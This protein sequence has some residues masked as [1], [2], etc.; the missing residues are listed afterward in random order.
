MFRHGWKAMVAS[1]WQCSWEDLEVIKGES[2]A[3]IYGM[4]P[5]YFLSAQVLGVRRDTP[6]SNR[7]LVIEPHLGDLL[8]ADGV[9]VTE[10]GP[11]P[12]SWKKTDGAL[13]FK[14]TIPAN[15]EARLALPAKPGQEEITI[16]GN[17][18]RGTVQGTRIVLTLKA[19]TYE[20]SY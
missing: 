11:V 1:P 8:E 14:V 15:T 3:H 4:F 16:N 10:F 2:K 5:G 6:A 20:G 12:V 13:H 7:Q 18:L 19:G 9:V 17:P